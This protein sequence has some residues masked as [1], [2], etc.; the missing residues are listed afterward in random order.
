[1][2][3]RSALALVVVLVVAG[4]T[5]DVPELAVAGTALSAVTI[6]P[7]RDVIP[8]ELAHYR[9]SLL[10][11]PA[12]AQAKAPTNDA[13]A[14]VIFP[15]IRGVYAYERWLDDGVSEQLSLR[16]IVNVAGL[17]PNAALTGSSQ[18]VVGS[19]ISLD[20]SPSSSPEHLPLTF[21]WRLA[22]HP[23]G[24]VAVITDPTAAMLALTPDVPGDYD[25]ELRAFDGELW[26][27]IV[28]QTVQ[29]SGN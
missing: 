29:V 21:A 15:P 10:A 27:P 3:C 1:M 17:A 6:A 12:D 20:A 23:A 18:A 19:R 25:L 14:V 7:P 22:R 13:P 2:T 26:S 28:E 9:W 24:S 16:A 4:C 11:A 8:G 5:D